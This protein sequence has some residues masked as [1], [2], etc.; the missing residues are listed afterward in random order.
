MHILQFPMIHDIL[1]TQL[2]LGQCSPACFQLFSCFETRTWKSSKYH[3]IHRYNELQ[4]FWLHETIPICIMIDFWLKYLQ[5]KQWNAISNFALTLL[6][7]NSFRSIKTHSNQSKNNKYHYITCFS[8]VYS[9]N[10]V[11]LVVCCVRCICFRT[12]VKTVFVI[13]SPYLCC[14]LLKHRYVL[15]N[16]DACMCVCCFVVVDVCSSM[17]IDILLGMLM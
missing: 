8:I 5:M 13:R 9:T 7:I 14:T 6:E 12:H 2:F 3:T 15:R 1:N 4:Q 17:W 11:H 10:A 16:I